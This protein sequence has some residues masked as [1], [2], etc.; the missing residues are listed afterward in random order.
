MPLSMINVWLAV[1]I[2]FKVIRS[3]CRAAWLS[4]KY[5]GET[6]GVATSVFFSSGFLLA[7]GYKS[8]WS[9]LC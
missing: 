8:S 5:V 7:V 3:W 4:E 9:P 1:D 6:E 2:L